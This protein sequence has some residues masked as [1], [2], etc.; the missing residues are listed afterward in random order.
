MNEGIVLL[1]KRGAVFV[2]RLNDPDRRNALSEELRDALIDALQDALRS[3]QCRVI[4]LTGAG[5]SFCAGGDLES[6]R[7]GEPMHVRTR[8]QRG[9]HLVRLIAAGSKPVIAAVNGPAHGAGL[10]IAAACDVVVAADSARFGAVFGKVGLMADLGLTWSLPLRVG[11]SQAKRLLYT[12][13]VLDADDARNLGLA[14]ERCPDA[15]LMDHAVRL[16]QRI[17]ESAPVA[18][19]LTKSAFARPRAGIEEAFAVELDAQTLLFET[20]DFSEGRNAFRE[21]RTARFEGR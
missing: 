10:S 12:A 15:D 17:A 9:Q 4:V 7:E 13:S 8:M 6:L 3:D 2:L 5:S 11:M 1:E 21:R 20:K 14:D 19:A 16:A 18:L